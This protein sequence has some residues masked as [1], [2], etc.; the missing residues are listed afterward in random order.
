MTSKSNNIMITPRG[1]VY[2]AILLGIIF[3]GALLPFTVGQTYDSYIHMFFGDHYN[4]SWFDPWDT[5]WY[6]GFTVTAYPPGSHQLISLLMFLFSMKTA[7]IIAQILAVILLVVGTYRFSRIW[8]NEQAAANASLLVVFASGIAETI[9]IFGQLPT[10]LSIAL[11]LNAT[12]H[13]ANWITFGTK[14]DI[15]P[16]LIFTAGATAVHHVTPIFGTILFIIPLGIAAWFAELRNKTAKWPKR[17]VNRIKW[18]APA[19]SRGIAIGLAMLALIVLVVFPYW[20]WSVTDPITQV[21]IHHGS[22]DNFIDNPNLGLMFFVIPWGMLIF[23]LPY[24]VY[25][26]ATTLMWPLGLSVLIAFILGTGGTTP[27]AEAIL[28]PAFW[29]LTLDRFTFWATILILP[30]AGLAVESLRVGKLNNV[31]VA[32]FGALFTRFGLAALATMFALCSILTALL[33][34]FRP[35]QPDFI[36]P[37]PIVQFM[38]E[39]Q[40]SNWRYLTLGFG[41]QFA[42]HSALIDADSVDGNYHSVRRLPSLTDYSVERLEN[43]KYSQ[44]IFDKCKSL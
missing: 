5:R 30:F 20:Y 6:T 35:T 23:I 39:D 25:K 28:G 29:I 40:H 3:H 2:L 32:S 24:V 18:L 31:L 17:L 19:P 42:Y 13:I 9:H 44:S 7:F 22:R 43:S 34:T 36:E 10:I 4:R 38:D 14:R 41:D 11:F 21:S 1:L 27:I 12:P 37:A 33:P 15:L 8:V 16:A 26:T